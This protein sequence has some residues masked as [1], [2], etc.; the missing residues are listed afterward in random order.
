MSYLTLDGLPGVWSQFHQDLKKLTRAIVFS[1]LI[2]PISC[3]EPRRPRILSAFASS[4]A[5]AA[6]HRRPG[7]CE[8]HE[9]RWRFDLALLGVLVGYGVVFGRGRARVVGVLEALKVRGGGGWGCLYCFGG[10]ALG[11]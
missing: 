10:G 2:D 3:D 1:V 4:T 6:R 8:Q 7:C 11:G 9:R 5:T